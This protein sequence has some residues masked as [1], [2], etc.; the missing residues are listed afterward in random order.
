[1]S[2]G[3]FNRCCFVALLKTLCLERQMLNA[4]MHLCF[5][6]NHTDIFRDVSQSFQIYDGELA[7]LVFLSDAIIAYNNCIDTVLQIL[8]F[9]L[10]F[11]PE[12]NSQRDY[13]KY[14]KQC[15]WPTIEKG[16][17]DYISLNPQHEDFYKRTEIFY[18]EAKP[19]RTIANAI[20]HHG[21]IV[22]EHTQIPCPPGYTIT[23]PKSVN[24]IDDLPSLQYMMGL[25]QNG[26]SDVFSP[27]SVLPLTIDFEGYIQILEDANSLIYDFTHYIFHYIGLYDATSSNTASPQTFRPTFSI[28]SGTKRDK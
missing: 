10:E 23:L 28:R 19:I 20:K 24:S 21:G 27:K 18:K 12:F 17:S 8:Y 5:A 15:K 26:S 22:S 25:I 13:E 14:L 7:K 11:M 9:G 16:L 2:N 4:Y 3:A 1:M 6:K